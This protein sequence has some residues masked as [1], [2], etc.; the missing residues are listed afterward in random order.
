[1]RLFDLT[2][3]LENNISQLLEQQPRSDLV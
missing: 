2:D 3:W 1:E